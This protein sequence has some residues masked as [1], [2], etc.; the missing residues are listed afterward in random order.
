MKKKGSLSFEQ[1]QTLC[2][3]VGN[4]YISKSGEDYIQA[5][6]KLFH[7]N[8]K[9]DNPFTI[10][11]IKQQPLLS[12]FKFEGV[13]DFIYICKLVIRPLKLSNG[14]RE[15][16]KI[17]AQDFGGFVA[18]DIFENSAGVSYILTC[19]IDNNEHIIKIGESRT[20]FQKRLGSYNCGVVFNWR[21]ASTTNIKMLQSMVV[22]RQPFN[23]YIYDCSKPPYILEWHGIKSVSFPSSKSL[24]VEDIMLKQ[25]QKEF[26]RKPLANIQANA[27]R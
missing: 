9:N 12:D 13:K 11:D 21:T 1:M 20:T 22:V 17:F 6:A 18:Q 15:N 26:G 24:A 5:L 10:D 3:K 8:N 23:L 16:E 7:L 2:D 19:P 25:F 27:Q 14:I 4:D